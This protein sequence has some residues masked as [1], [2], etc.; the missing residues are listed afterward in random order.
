MSCV[1]GMK[2]Q[3]IDFTCNDPGTIDQWQV[4]DQFEPEVTSIAGSVRKYTDVSIRV[5]DELRASVAASVST[6]AFFGMA[7][8]SAW[9]SAAIDLIYD[10]S[11]RWSSVTAMVSAWKPQYR[12]EWSKHAPV[13]GADAQGFIDKFLV[14]HP[15]LNASTVALW[16]KFISVYGTDRM[17]WSC[18]GMPL[19]CLWHPLLS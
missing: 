12:S 19:I 1:I 11:F 7:S 4:P 14:H 5:S 10:R 6:S 8:A 15:V 3:I 16:N 13:F 9:F 2:Q 17:D 18:Q